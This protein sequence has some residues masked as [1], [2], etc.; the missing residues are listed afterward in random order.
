[1]NPYNVNTTLDLQ[2][3]KILGLIVRPLRTRFGSVYGQTPP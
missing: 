3:Y 1:M 2:I